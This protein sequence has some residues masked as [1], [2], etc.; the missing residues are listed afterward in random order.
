MNGSYIE[1]W[2]DCF[3]LM[4][5]KH[6][7]NDWNT[8]SLVR[9]SIKYFQLF[10]NK[11]NFNNI[12]LPDLHKIDHFIGFPYFSLDRHVY[13]LGKILEDWPYSDIYDL[14]FYSNERRLGVFKKVKSYNYYYDLFKN[15]VDK[16][17]SGYLIENYYIFCVWPPR[18]TL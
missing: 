13:E 1:H 12:E 18:K 15:C 9:Y 4:E 14:K 16:L 3:L 10:L 2:A 11:N 6:E 7:K 17:Y 8:D 5:E